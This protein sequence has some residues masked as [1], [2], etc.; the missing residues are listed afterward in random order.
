MQRLF[1][2]FPRGW[3]AIGLLLL[4]VVIGVTALEESALYFSGFGL[5]PKGLLV[6]LVLVV[7]GTLLLIGLQTAPASVVFAS[8]NLASLVSSWVGSARAADSPL[9]AL[10]A[11]AIAVAVALMGPGSVSLDCRL[12]GPREI[13]IPAANRRS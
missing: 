5:E 4:R 11:I 12:H 9:A 8:V 1:S 10:Y 6:G 2:T 7:S 13:S 3:P